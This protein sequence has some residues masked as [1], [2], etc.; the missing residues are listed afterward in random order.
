[1]KKIVSGIGVLVFAL[2]MMCTTAFATEGADVTRLENLVAVSQKER[3][4][5]WPKEFEVTSASNPKTFSGKAEGSDLYLNKGVT[6]STK[7]W[8]SINNNR[9]E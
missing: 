7:Y 4:L 6:G 2:Y 9:D 5:Y 8:I 1:M 3:G